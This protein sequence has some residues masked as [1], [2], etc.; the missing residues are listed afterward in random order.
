MIAASDVIMDK[1]SVIGMVVGYSG[2]MFVPRIVI[3]FVVW[4]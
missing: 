4:V 3:V 2:M 1:S